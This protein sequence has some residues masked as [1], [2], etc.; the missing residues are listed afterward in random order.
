MPYYISYC[1]DCNTRTGDE[2]R[3]TDPHLQLVVDTYQDLVPDDCTISFTPN[4]QTIEEYL[5][6]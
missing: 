4:H 6:G 1:P 2:H 5:H 3:V